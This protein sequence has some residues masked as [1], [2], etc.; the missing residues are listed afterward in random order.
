M[1]YEEY[2]E[3]IFVEKKE[4]EDNVTFLEAWKS[5]FAEGSDIPYLINTHVIPSRP[6]DFKEPD[7]VSAYIYDSFAGEIPM[8][9]AGNDDDF[10]R[11]IINVAYKGEWNDE[12]RKTGASF[13]AGKV[14]RFIVLSKKP[15]SN[16]SAKWM[17]LGEK[18]WREKSMI[19]RRTHEYTHYYTRRYYGNAR[20]NLHDELMA[21]FFGIYA[22]FGQYQAKWFD[23][24][25]GVDGREEGRLS[26]YTGELSMEDM[27]KVSKTAG[28]CSAFLEKWSQSDGFKAM[29]ETERI[30]YLCSLGIKGML[31]EY[32]NL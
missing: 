11:L 14:N 1:T 32:E 4:P 21:D 17:G 10:E 30:D 28:K 7:E 9:V 15:Y 23:H 27:K 22:A 20:N 18:E 3:N 25:M 29:S 26:V 5:W 8:I 6:V 24:F 2:T 16:V 13:L 19:L 12:V 31:K